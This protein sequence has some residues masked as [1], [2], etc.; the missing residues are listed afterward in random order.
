VGRVRIGRRTRQCLHDAPCA[1]A[2]APKGLCA[3]VPRQLAAIGVGY[4][5]QPES[6]EA[7]RVARAL[8]L[9]AGARLRLRA[10]VDDRLQSTGWTPTGGPDPPEIWDDV[11]ELVVLSEEVDLLVIGSRRWGAPARVLLGG[12][13]E[14]LMHDAR[15]SVMVVP[16]LVSTG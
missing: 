14:E 13:G 3:D 9:A 8:A 6:R 1:L 16:R 2:V 11:I 4:D 10:V 7:L 15:C 12:T 5:G